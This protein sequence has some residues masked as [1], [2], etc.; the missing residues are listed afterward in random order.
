[1]SRTVRASRSTRGQPCDAALRKSLQPPADTQRGRPAAQG[2]RHRRRGCRGLSARGGEEVRSPACGGLSQTVP[3]PIAM[4]AA[5]AGDPLS[6]SGRRRARRPVWTATCT[7]TLL[8]RSTSA[9][10]RLTRRA[11]RLCAWCIASCVRSRSPTGPE[12]GFARAG[13]CRSSCSSKIGSFTTGRPSLRPSTA[14]IGG[15]VG[16]EV[17]TRRGGGVSS[18]ARRSVRG[19]QN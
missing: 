17:G 3:R 19:W 11:G 2:N 10:S 5:R 16:V 13:V 4:S 1:M 9:S 8:P 14:P 7:S 6:L 18:R 15:P 12:H